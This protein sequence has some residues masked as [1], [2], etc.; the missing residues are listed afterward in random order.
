[1]RT[2]SAIIFA[3][4]LPRGTIFT[5]SAE[6]STGGFVVFGTEVQFC[7]RAQIWLEFWP[8]NFLHTR[9]GFFRRRPVVLAPHLPALLSLFPCLLSLL[10]CLHLGSPPPLHPPSWTPLTPPPPLGEGPAACSRSAHGSSSSGSS[11]PRAAAAS[12]AEAACPHP[13]PPASW[14]AACACRRRRPLRG[15]VPEPRV[16]QGRGRGWAGQ[17]AR[18]G[19]RRH[20]RPRGPSRWAGRRPCK[21][22]LAMNIPSKVAC[23]TK[24]QR[25]NFDNQS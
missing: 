25:S 4:L 22:S 3:P 16:R 21:R 20:P 8:H 11:T 6:G 10:P 7:V 1:M 12:G 14:R 17:C 13:H 18:I 23:T 19:Q 9:V 5:D 15:S 24:N 2:A